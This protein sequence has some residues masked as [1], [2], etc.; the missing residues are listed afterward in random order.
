MTTS[1]R[2]FPTASSFRMNT[3]SISSMGGEERHAGRDE[4]GSLICFI[5][6]VTRV[7]GMDEGGNELSWMTR[8]DSISDL[9]GILG[10]E[11]IFKEVEGSHFATLDKM[12]IKS[13]LRHLF[14]EEESG[15]HERTMKEMC[16]DFKL[17]R[18]ELKDENKPLGKLYGLVTPVFSGKE[19]EEFI[20]FF[21]KLQIELRLQSFPTVMN[22]K[23]EIIKNALNDRENKRL[24]GILAMKVEHNKMAPIRER[25]E[26]SEDGI[27]FLGALVERYYGSEYKQQQL[28]V[29]LTELD[30]LKIKEGESYMDFC[31][32]FEGLIG[33]YGRFSDHEDG[34]LSETYKKNKVIKVLKLLGVDVTIFHLYTSID[35]TYEDVKDLLR[36]MDGDGNDEDSSYSARRTM[37][38]DNRRGGKY[39][40]SDNRRETKDRGGD[41]RKCYKCGKK[42]HI[43]TDCRGDKADTR[44]CFTCHKIGH[45]STNCPEKGK[46]N[47]EDV[48]EE[49]SEESKDQ[50]EKK[51]VSWGG[52]RK[53]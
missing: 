47:K 20:T 42:G 12:K 4:A 16:E 49:V 1:S 46:T 13:A 29:L 48:V 23:N 14:K 50:G 17:S 24:F 27:G 39:A 5:E 26:E 21:I 33:K 38:N 51:Q 34:F 18:R 28:A 30:V 35:K 45:I 6:G 7:R 10:M 32:R 53:I 22:S 52:G 40:G 36:R 15:D 2:E 19:G 31:D 25:F 44:E 43:A 8:K 3:T 9:I 41:S 11:E 37:G